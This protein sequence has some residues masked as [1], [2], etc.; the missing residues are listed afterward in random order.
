MFAAVF[1]YAYSENYANYLNARFLGNSI[2]K[3]G[4]P[5][6]AKTGKGKRLGCH[7]PGEKRPGEHFRGECC[8][9]ES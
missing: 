5:G 7:R 2:K 4:R 9:P 6:I 1:H 8:T 3:G